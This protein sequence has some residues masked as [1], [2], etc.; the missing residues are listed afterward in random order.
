MTGYVE[1]LGRLNDGSSTEERNFKQF[2]G[3]RNE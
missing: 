1:S 2:A 3:I